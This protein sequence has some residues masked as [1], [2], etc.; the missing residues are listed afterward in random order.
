MRS[1]GMDKEIGLSSLAFQRKQLTL[2][3]DFHPIELESFVLITCHL[4]FAFW[5]LTTF[6]YTGW[7]LEYL[8]YAMSCCGRP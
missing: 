2:S 7:D 5:I 8:G 1:L 4:E 3:P 6:F